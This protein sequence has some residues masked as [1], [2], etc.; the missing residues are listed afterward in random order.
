[1]SV[2]I[3][4]SRRMSSSNTPRL[5]ARARFFR[6]NFPKMEKITMQWSRYVPLSIGG[7]FMECGRILF[8]VQGSHFSGLTKFHDFSR[9]SP[10]NFKVF[11]SIFKVTF[12]FFSIKICN[13][14]KQFSRCC[15]VP[16]LGQKSENLIRGVFPD[17]IPFST[18]SINNHKIPDFSR[19]S[20]GI[21]IF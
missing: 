4:T 2:S 15:I 19:F 6:I 17:F 11:F 13:V 14:K 16:V 1:M 5:L 21:V 20:R 7:L 10:L 3:S 9:I 18:L 8:C 12:K